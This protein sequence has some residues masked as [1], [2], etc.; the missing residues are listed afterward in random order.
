MLTL[1]EGEARADDL[2]E[3]D[4]RVFEGREYGE[5]VWRS[6]R[7]PL[8]DSDG[9]DGIAV[10]K[11]KVFG[12]RGMEVCQTGAMLACVPRGRTKTRLFDACG[13]WGMLWMRMWEGA[14]GRRVRSVLCGGGESGVGRLELMMDD[15]A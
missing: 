5:L 11:T 10:A 15:A 6:L 14:Q 1:R 8:R 3:R 4:S 7:R 2:P 9:V 13:R 12:W